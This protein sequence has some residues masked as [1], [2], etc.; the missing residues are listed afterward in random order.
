MTEEDLDM[1]KYFWEEKRDLESYRGYKRIED[2]LK[3]ERPDIYVFWEKYKQA[4][5]ALNII[6][7]SV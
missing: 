5:K 7:G 6:F 3:I 2:Q 1:L 4:E